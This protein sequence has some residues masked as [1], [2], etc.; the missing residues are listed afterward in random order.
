MVAPACNPSY[1]EAEAGELLQPGRQTLQWA[2]IVPLY[3]SLGDTARCYLKKQTIII[4]FFLK[5]KL[6][7]QVS[8]PHHSD[9]PASGPVSQE[10]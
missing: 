8:L 10:T 4:F 3:T 5:E 6:N 2:E 9:P 1:W 7:S